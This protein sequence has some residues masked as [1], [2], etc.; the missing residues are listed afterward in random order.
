M[1][2]L[3]GILIAAVMT[4]PLILGNNMNKSVQQIEHQKELPT[5]RYEGTINGKYFFKMAFTQE[6]NFLSGTLISTYRKENKI[7]G[8]IDKDNAFLLTEYQDGQEVGVLE[9]RIITGG[10]LKGTWSTPDGKKWFPFLL[11]KKS[12]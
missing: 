6:D 9:G 12:V 7:D 11:V 3:T 10:Y 1:R 5:I 8:T 4:A 2:W